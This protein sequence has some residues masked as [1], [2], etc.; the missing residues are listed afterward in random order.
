[1][2]VKR[3]SGRGEMRA[4]QKWE[5]EWPIMIQHDVMCDVTYFSNV[6]KQTSGILGLCVSSQCEEI[7]RCCKIWWKLDGIL[8]VTAEL[9]HFCTFLELFFT[10]SHFLLLFSFKSYLKPL[11]LKTMFVFSNICS[12]FSILKNYFTFLLLLFKIF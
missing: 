2:G 9:T 12:I 7:D 1:M 10:R 6:S 5:L 3:I 11:F 8:K 4:V